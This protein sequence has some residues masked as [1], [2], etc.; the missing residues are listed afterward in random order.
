MAKSSNPPRFAAS[1]KYVGVST[2]KDVAAFKAA[3][4]ALAEKLHG[5]KKASRE[6]V[7]ALE[8]RAGI[9]SSRPKK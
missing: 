7:T 2:S 6:F 1:S 9:S 8:G 3:S 4:K 5:N